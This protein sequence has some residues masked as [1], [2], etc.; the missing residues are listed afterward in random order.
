MRLASN[1]NSFANYCGVYRQ[2][3]TEFSDKEVLTPEMPDSERESS[4]SEHN[5]DSSIAHEDDT[6][7]LIDNEIHPRIE[8]NPLHEIAG[9]AFGLGILLGGSFG[10]LPYITFKNFNLYLIALAL[11]HFLEFYTTARF[12]PGKVTSQSF[13][14]NNGRGYILSHILATLETLVECIFFPKWKSTTYSASHKIIVLSGIVLVIFG[15]FIRTA[16]MVTAG[17]SFSHYV[18]TKRNSDHELITTGIYAWSRHPS[19]L[20]F[21]WW[22]LGTQMC[23]LN[24]V[25]FFVFLIILWNFFHQRIKFEEKFLIQF[26]GEEYLRY[27]R[28][29]PVG[30]PFAS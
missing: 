2:D 10:L 18:K 9:T 22:A 30:I 20:G 24:I 21:F 29:V 26:F 25:S 1:E 3:L 7:I 8:E 19:Y 4:F 12:N 14:L 28:R 23:L 11:F 6:G 5:T 17:R 13:L 16:A 15:Q 27:R